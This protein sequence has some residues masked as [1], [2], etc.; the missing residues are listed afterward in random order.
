MTFHFKRSKEEKVRKTNGALRALSVLFLIIAISPLAC[1]PP[2]IPTDPVM[3]ATQQ[4]NTPTAAETAASALTFTAEADAQVNEENPDNNA[5][6]STFLQVDG[7]SEPAV[8][9]FIRFTVTGISG[10]IQSAQLRVYD[11]T[12]ASDNGP[13]IYA[14]G[15]AWTETEITWNNRPERTSEELDN[16]S[17]IGTKTWVEYDVTTAVTGDGTFSFVLAA[18]SSDAA[19]F[20]SREGSQSPELMILLAGSST[21]VV[22]TATDAAT[23]TALSPS[24]TSTSGTPLPGGPLLFMADADARVKESSPSTNYG[25]D[26][27]LHADGAGDSGIESFIRF[28]VTGVSGPVQSARLRV[29][30]TD[31]GTQ[32]GPAVYSTS[33][34]WTENEI[35]WDNRPDRAGGEVDNKGRLSTN[36]WAE[37]NVTSVVTGNGTFSFVLVADS[38]DGVIFSSRE[39]EQ[40]PQLALTLQGSDVSTAAPA[41]TATS[42]GDDVIF[43][44]AGD[45]S[46]CRN[47]NDELTAQLLDGIPGTIFTTGDNAYDS[48]T[49]DQ[50]LNCY[51]PTW[52]RHK[53]R[54]KP[55]PGNHDYLT[56]G[57]SAYF[58]YFDNVPSY[59]SY[60]LGRWRIYALNSEIDV[61]DNSPQ[62]TWLKA[63]L[64]SN[65]T[66]CVLAYWHRPRWSSGVNHGSNKESQTLWQIL[67][68]AGAELVL[69]GHEH[70]YERFAEMNAE[71]A[72]LSPGLREIV[73]GTGG[74]NHYEFGSALPA[75]EVRESS[76]FGVLKLTLRPD[77]YDW[78]FIPVAGST[79]TD[80]GSTSC[81]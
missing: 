78:E 17:S 65:P 18:D 41:I 76:T 63:D 74:R 34:S 1:T 49:M 16:K 57:A 36:S 4:L 28:T 7:A 47:D 53:E 24:A 51:D 54:T 31:N 5:G 9:S 70:N 69:N 27:T 21:P 25:A 67:Y 71:G 19:T 11:T 52:G 44:G 55:S 15:T 56:S 81:H 59:Y 32:D 2:A 45:I 22:G 66:Q 14:T 29:Y 8:E 58:Q 75:S 42:P 43:V 62:V 79:F 40:P 61:S 64:A 10:T 72:A 39:G 3:T 73:V 77:G 13:A 50:Y 37:Y 23:A 20:S 60:N 26:N 12:N 68:E 80:S 6:S 48:G 30:M 46:T 38:D 35:T 33:N